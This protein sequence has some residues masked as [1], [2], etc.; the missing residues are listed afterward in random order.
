MTI[1]NPRVGL[2]GAGY[3]ASWHA[4]A[5]R[6]TGRAEIK[7]VCDLSPAAAHGLAASLGGVDAY[8]DIAEL[9]DAKTCDAVHI[10]TPPHLHYAITK[11]CLEGGLHCFVEKP[12]ALANHEC[13]ELTTLAK[14]KNLTIGINHNF[15]AL[16]AYE[17]LKQA[18]A[19]GKIGPVD[20]V[21]VNW[22]F[23]FPPL[24]SG[25]FG[26]WM[27][28]APLNML[29]EFG[30]HLLAFIEDLFGGLEDIHVRVGK[31]ITIPGG[32]KHYQSWQV[33][34]IAGETMVTL[35]ISHVEGHDDRTL[36]LRGASGTAMLDFA[37]DTLEIRRANNA[38]IIASPLLTELGLAGQHLKAGFGN[39]FKQAKSLNGLSPYA[40][41]FR[42]SIKAFYDA[43]ANGSAIDQRF[44]PEAATRIMA[45]V[46]KVGDVAL[47]L[48]GD[49]P[50]AP[51]RSPTKTPTV[52]VIGGTG[53]IGRYLTRA[54]AAENLGVRVFSRGRPAIFDD[55]SDK[56]S[57]FSGS[58][59]NKEDIKAAMAGID[60]VYHLAKAEEKTWDG[61]V[62]N[63]VKVTQM[64][65]ECA[66][67]IG[68][69]RFIYTGTIDS[70]DASKP[71]RTITE[72]TGL[73]PQ[74]E[75]R[76]LYARSKAACEALLTKMHKDENLP[77]VIVRPGIVI[78]EGGPLQHWGIG[79][80]AGAGAVKIWGPGKNILPLVLVEDVADG[81]VK[82]MSVAGIEGQSFNLIGEPMMSALDYFDE[83]HRR[84]GAR[85]NVS[86]G[87]I[88][89][90][91]ASDLLKHTLKKYV[92]RKQNLKKP[93]FR[94]WKSRTQS[95]PFANAKAKSGLG[96]TPEQ[97]KESFIQR[98]IVRANLF[99]F[100][101]PKSPS[102]DA[103][104][105]VTQLV[106]K[107]Q[108]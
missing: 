28:R 58:L 52:L 30:A 6:A 42:G 34:G 98:A 89:L 18:I 8:H 66:L 73:D 76:N 43:L 60:T 84:L 93:V 51:K 40:L 103:A 71:D 100:T 10:L 81:L 70:Y 38:D 47:P 16:P 107:K 65:A 13:E 50:I 69:K 108:A 87:S 48:I 24:R 33:T 61:Y 54:L 11:Q 37:A 55:I 44:S 29:H 104:K 5:I 74:V 91:Y 88:P 25:P 9:I 1:L 59:K 90:Y 101:G 78:G 62:E 79:R 63:D 75:E 15:L 56:V 86:S 26:M 4:D 32:I 53:F 92:L 102:V 64:I 83:I 7:A 72:Q 21:E 57:V 82:A 2:I 97:D 19:D 35:N 27:L 105:P 46:N 95:S 49:A 36:R 20:G 3:I 23:P 39:G 22:R 106:E 41:G 14:E 12:F 68:I 99:G 85:I 96:W 77:L 80:W 17:R 31:P 67:E 45:L 94:D